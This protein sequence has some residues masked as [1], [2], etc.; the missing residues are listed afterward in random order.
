VPS[1]F[2]WLTA[3]SSISPNVPN[4]WLV[5]GALILGLLLFGRR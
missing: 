4:Y 3:P 5:G 2:A 1:S